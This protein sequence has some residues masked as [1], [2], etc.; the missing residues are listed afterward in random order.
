MK[1]R[2]EIILTICFVLGNIVASWPGEVVD[3]A[4]RAEAQ[5]LEIASSFDSDDTGAIVGRN[6]RPG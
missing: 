5:S 6:K 4:E 2:N 1:F 3:Y